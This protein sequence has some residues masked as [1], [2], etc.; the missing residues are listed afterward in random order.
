MPSTDIKR[1]EAFEM[2]LW[3]K[4]SW[5]SKISNSEVLKIVW[6]SPISMIR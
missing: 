3:T 2:W 1:I 5:T 6:T 4:I